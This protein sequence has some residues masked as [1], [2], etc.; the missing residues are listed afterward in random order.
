MIF[1]PRSSI[2]KSV[3]DCRLSGVILILKFKVHMVAGLV[4]MNSIKT[5]CLVFLILNG[6]GKLI[7]YHFRASDFFQDWWA[8]VTH[9]AKMMRHF[10]K[11]EHSAILPTFIKL[12]FVIKIFALSFLSGCYCIDYLRT[13]TFCF[14]EFVDSL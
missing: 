14:V 1:D 5:L 11:G 6:I 4:K 10:L 12:P 9:G 7:L 13:C 2:V 8:E 3:F